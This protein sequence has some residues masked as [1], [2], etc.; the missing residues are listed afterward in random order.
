MLIQAFL[1]PYKYKKCLGNNTV[2]HALRLRLHVNVQ[3]KCSYS[4][5]GGPEE[6]Q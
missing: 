1:C 3:Q 4:Q 5:K 2:L 6:F